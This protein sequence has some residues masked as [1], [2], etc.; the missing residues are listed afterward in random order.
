MLEF[1]FTDF[2]YPPWN[3]F[4]SYKISIPKCLLAQQ[5]NAKWHV[6]ASENKFKT[7]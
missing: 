6:Q 1:Y 5:D 7:K 3:V 2:Y 4:Y